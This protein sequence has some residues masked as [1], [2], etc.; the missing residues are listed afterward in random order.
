MAK[1]RLEEKDEFPH[2]VGPESN[3]NESMYFN[4]FDPVKKVGGWFRIGNRVNEGYA[5]MSVCLFLPDGKVGF[6]YGRP[7]IT[8]NDKHEAGGLKFKVDEPFKRFSQV[9][10][11]EILVLD[12]PVDMIDPKAAFLNNPTT[13]CS[14]KMSYTGVSPLHGGEPTAPDQQTMY[15]RNF[16]TGHFNQH[17]S[18]QGTITVGDTTYEIN[19]FGWRDHSWGPRYWQNIWWYRLLIG[20]FDDDMGF[21]ILKITDMDKNTRRVGV[22]FR[23]G[24][25]EELLDVDVMTDYSDDPYHRSMR[26]EARTTDG[27]FTADGKVRTLLPLRNRRKTDDGTLHTRIA[28]GMTEWTAEG[29]TGWGICEYLDQIVDDQPVGFPH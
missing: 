8:A 18:G 29:R 14:I 2:P 4:V 9:Y 24:K 20:S 26:L 1:F 6:M 13:N 10:E 22:V 3:F 5:E 19:G 25:Y 11:G 27:T 12:N 15:G 7:E 21:M 17:T 23:D 28:E 16:S